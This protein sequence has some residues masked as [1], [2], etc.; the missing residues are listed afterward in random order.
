MRI[1]VTSFV[2]ALAVAALCAAAGA[3]TGPALR[4][5]P[6]S[7]LAVQGSGFVPR[8]VVRLRLTSAG[9]VLGV[10]VVRAG[11]GGGFT[12]RLT[13]RPACGVAVVTAT[14]VGDRRARV[15]TGLTRLCPPPPPIP[16]PGAA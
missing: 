12:A 8:T 3:A 13:A 6:G 1:A 7:M 11:A 2:C 14:G 15:A 16:S 9:K 4:V 5:V 10:V